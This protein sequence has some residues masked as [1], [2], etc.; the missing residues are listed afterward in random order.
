MG[1][2][3]VMDQSLKDECSVL[4]GRNIEVAMD[5][6]V[7]DIIRGTNDVFFEGIWDGM[8][9]HGFIQTHSKSS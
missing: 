7:R 1:F 4:N 9:F 5:S 8:G 6:W 3:L 2:K